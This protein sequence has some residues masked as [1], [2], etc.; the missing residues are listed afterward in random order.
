[1]NYMTDTASNGAEVCRDC[2][3]SIDSTW[4]E[5]RDHDSN[6]GVI[7][8]ISLDNEHVLWLRSYL[9]NM[10]DVNNRKMEKM[11]LEIGFYCISGTCM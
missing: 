7:A 8:T 9:E 5:R 1:M 3:I 2:S 11:I 4:Q 6:H 10:K